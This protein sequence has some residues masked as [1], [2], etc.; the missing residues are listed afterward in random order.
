[1][2]NEWR[3]E[4]PGSAPVAAALATVLRTIRSD[5]DDIGCR[6]EGLF[7]KPVQVFSY[8]KDF[9]FLWESLDA[10]VSPTNNSL[11]LVIVWDGVPEGDVSGTG[12]T[13]NPPPT[14]N[15]A[16]YVTVFDWIVGLCC[17]A[18]KKGNS[19]PQLR[20]HV[21]DLNPPKHSKAF[22]VRMLPSLLSQL[23]WVRI[24]RPTTV[25]DL[26]TALTNTIC[27]LSADNLDMV[28]RLWV[29]EFVQPEGLHKRHSVANLIGPRMLLGG[30]RV[31]QQATD[32]VAALEKLMARLA[33]NSGKARQDED[34][35]V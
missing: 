13:A 15:V 2:S 27:D 5:V 10:L 4:N 26:L 20:I 17:A 22:G 25:G 19:F 1:M 23:P 31:P 14:I 9:L 34:T 21:L 3:D 29:N 16:D 18:G 24:Y 30:M 11:D 35:L 8:R 6:K 28:K 7:T 12:A 33:T 32:A